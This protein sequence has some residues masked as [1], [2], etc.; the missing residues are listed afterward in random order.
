MQGTLI[1][2]S[3]TPLMA[4]NLGLEVVVVN[5]FSQSRKHLDL[6]RFLHEQPVGVVGA[7][8]S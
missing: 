2:C 3:G 7:A 8:D 5:F 6:C 1:G 4:G